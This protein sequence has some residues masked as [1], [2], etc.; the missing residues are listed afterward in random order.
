MMSISQKQ[1][2]IL[3]KDYSFDIFHQKYAKLHPKPSKDSYFSDEQE[4][5]YE[6]FLDMGN[7]PPNEAGTGRFL[8]TR[9][10]KKIACLF[11]VDFQQRRRKT[12]SYLAFQA[13]QQQI[14]SF[15]ECYMS[16]EIDI[17][18]YDLSKLD[19]DQGIVHVGE[20]IYE[21]DLYPS[22]TGKS[23]KAKGKKRKL[24]EPSYIEVFSLFHAMESLVTC[25]YLSML[26]FVDAYLCEAHSDEEDTEPDQE[27]YSIVYGRA[28][29]DR[30]A[31]ISLKEC[32]TLKDLLCVSLHELCH[33]IGFDHCNS[34][35]C[36]MNATGT[37]SWLFMSP[38][39][40]RKL[41]VFHSIEQAEKN[42]E[43]KVGDFILTRYET[44]LA[45]LLSWQDQLF[46]REIAW[47]QEIIEILKDL[48]EEFS[49]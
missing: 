40:M 48:I 43:R 24:N 27:P 49:K 8:L 4:Q 41:K 30:I 18:E 11:F 5:S 39:N 28:C 38:V 9:E 46:D 42:G 10:R 23:K 34:W 29:G 26:V 35:K 31:C 7:R 25:P 13:K 45:V 1:K 22:V 44:V 21:L 37:D 19:L 16:L 32:I 17:I 33:T 36:L 14:K 15:I 2:K 20:Y 12:S 47:L 6:E 3:G